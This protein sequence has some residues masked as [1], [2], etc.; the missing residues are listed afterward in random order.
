MIRRREIRI[1]ISTSKLKS[2]VH[3]CGGPIMRSILD[4]NILDKLQR[5][6]SKTDLLFIYITFQPHGLFQV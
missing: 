2:R 6:T 1:A 3:K 4:Y 5:I